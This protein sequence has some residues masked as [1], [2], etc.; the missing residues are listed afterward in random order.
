[1]LGWILPCLLLAAV[2]PPVEIAVDPRPGVSFGLV[3]SGPAGGAAAGEFR[4]GLRLNGSQ[5]EMPL[6][7]RSELAGDRLRLVATVRYADVPGDWLSHSRPE[8]LDYRIRADVVGAGTV[9][10][11]GAL[12]WSDVS[13][14]GGREALSRFVALGSLELTSLSSTRTEGRAVLS[15][16]NPF[17]FPITI[18]AADYRLRVNRKEIGG[19]AAKGR[20][21]KAGK[22]KVAL[23]L[24]F[25]LEEG[26]FRAAAG[27]SWAVGADLDA[28]VSGSLTLRLP[29][30][31]LAVPFDLPGRL[32]TDGARSGV[33]SHPAGATSLSPR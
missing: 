16:T 23:E 29:G 21:L 13:F 2:G 7:G 15:V 9:S 25:R 22:K 19:G 18:A 8:A 33:F 20:I 27:D 5:V 14:V 26:T 24:P 17:A 28:A 4:G 1:M 31:D 32:G 6:A 3:L 10:W 30:G 12:A 11:E